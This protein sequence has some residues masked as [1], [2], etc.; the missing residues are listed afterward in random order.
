MRILRRTLLAIACLASLPLLGL[1]FGAAQAHEI[2]AG[3]LV[4]EHP[5]SRA[6]T[7]KN[8]VVYMIVENHG[9]DAD[10][11][12]AASVDVA[13]MAMLHVNYMD[14][15]VM[16]MRMVDAIDIP[17]GGQAELKPGSFHIMLMDLKG[18]LKEGQM[19]PMTLTFAKT[20]EVKVNVMVE[21]AG[22]AGPDHHH[23]EKKP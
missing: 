18:P 7:G 4:I 22:A 6:T 9:A 5:W 13:G 16:K 12:T 1:P 23:D 20:G 11:L 14:G 19:F 15:D 10:K 8:G 2:K 17:A 21:A 3:D